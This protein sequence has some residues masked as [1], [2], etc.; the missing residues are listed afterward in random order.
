[1]RKAHLWWIIPV[2]LLLL[3]TLTR[4]IFPS[5]IDDVC[6]EIPCSEIEKYNPDILW[7]IPDYNGILINK[8]WCDEILKLNKTVGMHGINHDYQEFL[9]NI[10]Q[11]Q[12]ENGVRTFTDC[13]NQAPTKF[14]P[15]Q[16]AIS[17]ENKELIKENNL[18]LKL[19]FNQ[20]FHKVYHCQ[21]TGLFPNWFVRII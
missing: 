15:P 10:T 4:N 1:M 8:T 21:D 5:E 19:E 3:F 12:L 17:N 2:C 13:F 11:E 20:L 14:K 7:V 6:P 9:G 16:L 18:S